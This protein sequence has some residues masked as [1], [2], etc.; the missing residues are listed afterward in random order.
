MIKRQEVNAYI[1]RSGGDIQNAFTFTATSPLLVDCMAHGPGSKFTFKQEL[2]C[3]VCCVTDS[4]GRRRGVKVKLFLCVIKC[5]TLNIHIWKSKVVLTSELGYPSDGECFVPLSV[6]K[7]TP[8]LI[9]WD[10]ELILTLCIHADKT[11]SSAPQTG[12]FWSVKMW[13]NLTVSRRA[14]AQYVAHTACCL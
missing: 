10:S 11:G 3:F 12:S 1:S 14:S 4:R 7:A 6:P 2:F 8:L 13:D 9:R 5:R